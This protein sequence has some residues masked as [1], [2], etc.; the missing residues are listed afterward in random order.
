M[1]KKSFT[2]C[3]HGPLAETPNPSCCPVWCC[4]RGSDPSATPQPGVTKSVA[5][6][7]AASLKGVD[8]L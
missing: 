3:I 5:Y 4:G 6:E 8:M 1:V 2:C 7:E